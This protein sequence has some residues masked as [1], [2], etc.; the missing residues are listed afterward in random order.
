MADTAPTSK[1]GLAFGCLGALATYAV[2]GVVHYR[3]MGGIRQEGLRLGLSVASAVLLGL[4]LQSF[5]HLARGYG[6]GESS[7]KELLRR[8]RSGEPPEDGKAVIA[9]GAI[10]ALGAPLLAPLSGVPC[11]FYL[12]RMYYVTFRGR[13]SQHQVPVYW[14]YASRPFA[15]DSA[16]ARVRVLAVSLPEQPSERRSGADAIE[17][18]RRLVAST[19]FESV[20]G[21]LGAVGSAFSMAKDVFTDDDGEA[22]RD[23]KNASDERDPE[24]LQLEEYVLPVDAQASAHG[25]WSAARGG[26]VVGAA[27]GSTV[28][29]VLGPPEKLTGVGGTPHKYG[30]Y[31][32]T[33]IVLTALGI[34]LL[35]LGARVL[36]TH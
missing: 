4:G 36:P 21:S 12:Y 28:A 31:V 24:S 14:G 35:W 13:R 33:A 16:A 25:A 19:S 29:V 27:I 34:G 7:L 22:R 9:T 32:V 26:I 3:L 2:L 8:A 15:L 18:A 6:G 17:R 1:A 5:W 11:V 23:W 30:S 10:R 20:S